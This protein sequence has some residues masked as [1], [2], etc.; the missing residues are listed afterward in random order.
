M[1]AAED[2]NIAAIILRIDS[3][4]GSAL[5]SEII[6]RAISR[7]KEAGKPVIVSMSDVAASGGYYVASAA[8]VI[9]ADPG[10]LTGSIGGFAIRPVL[11]GPF[12]K[13]DIGIESVTRGRHA[14]FL[15]SGE[16]LSPAALATFEAY[17]D[18]LYTSPSAEERSKATRRSTDRAGGQPHARAQHGRSG[19]S[20]RR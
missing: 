9:V 14:D 8:G 12:D 15:R 20:H 18:V 16:K 7:A 2:P 4:G 1:G 6:W 19:R 3:P 10:T 13:L 17:C 11:G 5:A